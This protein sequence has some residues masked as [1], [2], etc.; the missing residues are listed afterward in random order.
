[1]AKPELGLKRQCMSCGA[2]FYDLNKNPAVCPK[3]GTVFQAS[4]LAPRVPAPVVARAAPAAA[5]DEAE[6]EADRPRDGVP[7]RGRGRARPTRICRART[8]STS[9]TTSP[10]RTPSSRKR[11]RARTT[12][13]T[14]STATSRTTKRL[15]SAAR[16]DY[17]DALRSGGDLF[18]RSIPTP[19]PRGAIAQLGERLNGIQEVGGSIP[20]G[21]TTPSRLT[22]RFAGVRENP[23]HVRDLGRGLGA[24]RRLRLETR[25]L[26]LHFGRQSPPT[27]TRF[28]DGDRRRVRRLHALD[29]TR[30]TATSGTGEVPRQLATGGRQGRTPSLSHCRDHSS[31]GAAMRFTLSPRGKRASITARTRSGARNAS[32]IVLAT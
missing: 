12:S 4:A 13:P 31:S 26:E 1:M 21:S 3:C 22:T 15:E 5:D 10:T 25:G 27:E 32:G 7:R 11:R 29:E 20:P 17:R 19:R 28:L 18:P 9:A 2:K 8:I 30:R 16:P 14:S 24:I 23:V 6:I